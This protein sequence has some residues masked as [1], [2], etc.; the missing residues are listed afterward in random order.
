MHHRC[1]ND[2]VIV[3]VC[4]SDAHCETR[5]GFEWRRTVSRHGGSR[6]SCSKGDR[7]ARGSRFGSLR[8]RE[9]WRWRRHQHVLDV[10]GQ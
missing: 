5:C 3:I 8:R 6:S 9:S 4:V 2:D 7:H 1:S 10:R